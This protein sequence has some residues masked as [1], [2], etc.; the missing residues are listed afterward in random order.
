MTLAIDHCRTTLDQSEK[1]PALAGLQIAFAALSRLATRIAD[2]HCK[3]RA[4]NH[5]QVLDDRILKD[6]GISRCEILCYV[7]G[8]QIE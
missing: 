1:S 3:R 2:S 8:R 4:I 5:L 7:R 6:I